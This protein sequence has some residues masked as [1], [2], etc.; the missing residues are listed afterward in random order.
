MKKRYVKAEATFIELL[1][2]E[3]DVLALSGVT[4]VSDRDDIGWLPK[5]GLDGFASN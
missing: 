3:K 5:D 1:K 2:K 4:G